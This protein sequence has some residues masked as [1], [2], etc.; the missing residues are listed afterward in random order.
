MFRRWMKVLR[1]GTT[2]LMTIFI[3]GWTIPLTRR[4]GTNWFINRS[5]RPV[6]LIHWKDLAQ[7]ND[8][9]T[10]V[11]ITTYIWTFYYTNLWHEYSAQ[12]TWM[13]NAFMVLLCYI[14]SW[15][16]VWCPKCQ[17]FILYSQMSVNQLSWFTKLVWMICSWISFSIMTKF[18]VWRI[19]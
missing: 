10:A 8:S 9:F 6:W 11:S 16:S 4:T 17:R 14:S 13:T 5:F 18:S 12:V 19:L 15:E 1:I 2:S 3:F 7:K